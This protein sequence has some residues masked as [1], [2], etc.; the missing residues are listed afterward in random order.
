MSS[1]DSRVLFARWQDQHDQAAAAELTER[2]LA[3][4]VGLARSRLAPALAGHV[5]AEDVVQSALGAFFV[6]VAKGDIKLRDGVSLWALLARIV[7]N[8]LGHAFD[9]VTAA[10]RATGCEQHFGS[11]DSLHALDPHAA[12]PGPSPD[13][14]AA[15]A[16][17]V[18]A[19]LKDVDALGPGYR[20]VAELWLTGA[21]VEESAR[22]LGASESYVTRARHKAK[23]LAE[24]REV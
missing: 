16:D 23:E 9:R 18:T 21:T 22:A 5:E 11:A 7:R 15:L 17:E 2:Y 19:W 1:V 20:R 4:L 3:R 10:K 24:R 13:E 8:K 12:D 6:G 14:A